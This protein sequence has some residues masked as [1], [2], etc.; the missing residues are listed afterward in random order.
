MV[1]ADL[2]TEDGLMIKNL[3]IIKNKGT[4]KTKPNVSIQLLNEIIQHYKQYMIQ[5]YE[6][7]RVLRNNLK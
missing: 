7:P 5:R 3:E 6:Q 4:L 1:S 2:L